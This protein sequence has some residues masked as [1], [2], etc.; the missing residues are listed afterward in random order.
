MKWLVV[1]GISYGVIVVCID[2]FYKNFD[3]LVKVFKVDLSK[4]VIG[5][6]GI[7]GS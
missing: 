2:L 3:D 4:V 6:G 5:F 7:V 1:I